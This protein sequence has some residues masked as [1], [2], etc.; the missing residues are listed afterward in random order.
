MASEQTTNFVKFSH[1]CV[2]TPLHPTSKA[3]MPL[4]ERKLR[5]ENDGEEEGEE[6]GGEDGE[7][8]I[9]GDDEGTLTPPPSKP[10]EDGR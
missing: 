5:D 10:E 4:Y 2:R 7:D 8:G 3:P 1:S 9:E 6:E